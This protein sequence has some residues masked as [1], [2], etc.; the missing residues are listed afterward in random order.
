MVMGG[1]KARS[2]R[3]AVWALGLAA[4]LLVSALGQASMAAPVTVTFWHALG[5]EHGTILQGLVDEFNASQDQVRVEL[6]YQG[7]YSTLM[8]KLMAAVAAG[9]P[10]T[11]AGSYN[12]WTTIFID[13]GAIV[14]VERFVRDPEV[15]LS[16]EELAD[17]F[18]AFLEANTWDGVLYS[19]PFNKSVQILYYNKD[20]LD[21][22]GVPVPSTMEELAR[23][24]QA[25][26]EATG[27]AGF[28]MRPDVD[29]FAA[30]LR[31]F[32]GRWLDDGGMP[33]FAGEAGVKALTFIRDLAAGG[34]AYAFDG[35]LDEEFNK[36]NTAMF[37]HSNSTI[38][39]VQQGATFAWGTAPVPAG[40]A[41]ASTVAGQDLVIFARATPEQ[42]KAAWAF[43][44]WLLSPEVNARFSV[45]TGYLPVRRSALDLPVLKEHVATAPEQYGAGIASL[46]RL[47]FDPSIPAWNDMRGFISEAVE[48]VLLTGADPRAALLDAAA[49]SERAIREGF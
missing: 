32:G 10:P 7:G 13:A 9:D 31:A 38:P 34:A 26:K 8:Q 12:N 15:G 49:K 30:F 2:A 18:P 22:A 37:I 16:S 36:V 29:T 17:F 14:P 46:D 11:M 5:G 19:L 1:A 23:A 25:V 43:L 4:M 40:V 3:K 47:V 41:A 6:A 27:V 24:A 28:A 44:K 33:A 39:W 20:L 21:Q 35:W 48:R 42:Q 45:G